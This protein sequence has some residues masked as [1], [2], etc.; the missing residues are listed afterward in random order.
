A[1]ADGDSDRDGGG[2]D[3]EDGGPI[4]VRD[5][6]VEITDDGGTFVCYVTI[7]DGHE[8][9]CGNCRDDDGDGRV[10]WR[11]RECL[12]PCDNTEGPALNADI[13]GETGGPCRADCYFDF[14]NGPGNDDCLWDHRCDPLAVAPDFPPEGEGCAF[15]ADRVGSRDCPADQSEQCLTV[16]PPLTPNG[17]DCFGCCT[18][19][20]L[21]GAFVWIGALDDDNQ[22]TCTFD[23]VDDPTA[24]PPCTPV[25]DCFNDCGPCEICLGKDELPPGCDQDGD[26]DGGVVGADGGVPIADG[27]VPPARCDPGVQECGQPGDELC[28]RDYYC[29]TGCC[30]PTIF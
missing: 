1:D 2:W 5:G 14:G 21:S 23:L 7:C 13:G 22:G 24:C 27:G 20:E 25:E 9:E 16:C 3:V 10:D 11:D 26:R 19:P 15:D 18:F 29:V 12:G 4:E 30:Q 6:G 28:A 17:C 8:L